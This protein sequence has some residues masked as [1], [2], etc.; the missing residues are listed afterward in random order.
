MSSKQY[1]IFRRYFY[2]LLTFRGRK[3]SQNCQF[4]FKDATCKRQSLMNQFCQV[5]Q[6]ILI[7]SPRKWKCIHRFVNENTSAQTSAKAELWNLWF[8]FQ[9]LINAPDN[10]SKS[11]VVMDFCRSR[12]SDAQ[13]HEEWVILINSIYSSVLPHILLFVSLFVRSSGPLFL[14]SFAPSLSRFL[15]FFVSSFLRSLVPSF[16]RFFAASSLSCYSVSS[17]LRFFAPLFLRFFVS[18]FLRFIALSFL[19]FFVLSFLRFLIPS[20]L[21][22]VSSSFV[23]FLTYSSFR[24][25]F[26]VFFISMIFKKTK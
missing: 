13:P 1:A 16:L 20:L 21:P 8:C 11:K 4:C 24:T 22:F 2:S 9:E 18:S 15:R 7:Q 3:F 6:R 26:W 14:R 19:R 23:C 17:F 5:S 12:A 25:N 10:I